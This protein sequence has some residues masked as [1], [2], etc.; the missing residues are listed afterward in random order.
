MIRC[1]VIGCE[2]HAVSKG[3]CDKHRK[4]LARKGT[5]NSTR[6]EGW[7]QR[8]NH[9]LYQSWCWMR[10]QAATVDSHWGNFWNFVE[11]VKDRP[12]GCTLRRLDENK[13]YGP[14]NWT[15]KHKIEI[16]VAHG[17]DSS[18]YHNEY[19]KEYRRLNPNKAKEHDLKKSFGITYE[20]FSDM[21]ALQNSVC[22]ICKKPERAVYKGVVRNLAVDHDHQTG[23]IRGLL[24][25]QCNQGIGSLQHD[26]ELFKVAIVYLEKHN[27]K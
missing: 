3:L 19:V 26:V 1:N 11:D 18:K 15:W 25:T 9:P 7:G 8:E 24:C 27:G 12:D 10:R 13:P 17:V 21:K 16:D 23:K 6:P 4:R 2:G 14:T 5:L 22:A 20:Q